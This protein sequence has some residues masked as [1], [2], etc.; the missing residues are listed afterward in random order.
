MVNYSSFQWRGATSQ[1]ARSH[2]PVW[3]QPVYFILGLV[4]GLLANN[5]PIWKVRPEKWVFTVYTV[6]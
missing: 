5:G 2:D 3:D 6:K 1:I 4:A